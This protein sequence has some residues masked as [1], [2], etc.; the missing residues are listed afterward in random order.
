MLTKVIIYDEYVLACLHPF[1]THRTSG[2]RCDVLQRRKLTGCRSN[3]SSIIHSA[4]FFQSFNQVGNGRSL[5]TDSHIDTEYVLIFLVDDRIYRDSRLSC[6]TVADDELSLSTSDR[7]HR[8]DSLDTGLKR[9][10]HG[11]TRDDTV[12]HTLDRTKLIGIDRSF[13]VDRLSKCVYYTP[14]HS[15]SDRYRHDTTGRLY[16]IALCDTGCV[17]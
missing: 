11:L 4:V 3:D 10:I 14:L 8:I 2:I 9:S 13:S 12:C 6:L 1:F 5:L 15:V 7:H 17:T 16:D